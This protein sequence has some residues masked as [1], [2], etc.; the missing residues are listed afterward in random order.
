MPPSEKMSLIEI[1]PLF[2]T[3]GTLVKY[4]EK[5]MNS[6]PGTI[7]MFVKKSFSM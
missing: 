2:T 1:P 3:K 6:W 5:T 4:A 7:F